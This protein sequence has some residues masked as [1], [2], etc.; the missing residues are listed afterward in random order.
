MASHQLA[1][2]GVHRHCGC[3]DIMIL[4]CH[5]I[6]QHHMIKGSCYFIDRS[7][8]M[9]SYHPAKFGRHRHYSSEYIIILV[10]HTI[11]QDHKIKESKDFIGRSPSR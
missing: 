8:S 9:L 10:C 1:T 2:F 11:S 5:M 4:G 3:G 6:S 7:L